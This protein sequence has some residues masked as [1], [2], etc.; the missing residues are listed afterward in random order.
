MRIAYVSM[1]SGVPVFG[2]K[3][4]SIHVQEMIHALRKRG[5]Q[6]ELFSPSCAGEVPARLHGVHVHRLP[7]VPKVERAVREQL[8]LGLNAHL[9]TA[10][11]REAPFDL[12]YERYSLWSFAAMA[13]AREAGVPGLLEVN[14]P[15]IDEQAIYRSLVDRASAETVAWRVFETASALVAVSEEVADY[16]RRVADVNQKV[17]VV[18]NGVDPDRF[19][20]S[21]KSE[22][23]NP[24]QPFTVGF[25][26]TLKAW[27]GLSVLAEAF[28]RL[29]RQNPDSR[30]LIVGDGTE[31][32]ALANDLASRALLHAAQLI[33][34][35]P[36]SDVPSWFAR[37]DAAV[38]PYPDLAGFYFSPLKVYEYMAA[39][40]PVVASRIGQLKEVIADGV[41]G[42][43]VNPGAADALAAALLR[44]KRDP[45][46]RLRLG[47]AARACVC[48]KHTWDAVAE[49]IIQIGGLEPALNL[50]S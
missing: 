10:L 2:Q 41:N 42:L 7:P 43:L 3:G 20:V 31:R 24:E 6:V 46:L 14:A 50:D 8:C 23:Q 13:Y 22:R 9:R 32:V 19:P 12:V 36:P 26:G 11:K 29:H 34:A 27:H 40:L 28:A 25:I 38:A 15:L 21:A 47:K 4:C 16:L 39:G 5:A 1:D 48:Q 17:H 35:V 18:P 49:Q 37:M 44:L 30:L 33:G 45:G